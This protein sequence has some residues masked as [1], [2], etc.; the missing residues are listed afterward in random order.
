[1]DFEEYEDKENFPPVVTRRSDDGSKKSNRKNKA[2][3]LTVAEK[4]RVLRER[5]QEKYEEWKEQSRTI[6]EIIQGTGNYQIVKK[7]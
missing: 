2:K 1:M 6:T 5:I 4:A 7:S 3:Q